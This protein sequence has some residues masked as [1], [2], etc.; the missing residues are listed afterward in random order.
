MRD[1]DEYFEFE[2]SLNIIYHNFTKKPNKLPKLLR[3]RGNVTFSQTF[4]TYNSLKKI[5]NNLLFHIVSNM[6]SLFYD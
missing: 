3:I 2:K 5:H 6:E 1:R 4:W